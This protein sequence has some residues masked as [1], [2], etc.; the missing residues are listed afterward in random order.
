MLSN[1]IPILEQAVFTPRKL[2]V[3]C[4]GAGFSGLLLAYKWKHE[5][6]QDIMD[7]QIYEKNTDVGGTWLENTYP[8]VA[9]DVPAHIYTFPFEPNPDWSSFYANGSEIW[10]YIKRTA[11]KYALHEPIQFNSKVISAVWDEDSSQWKIRVDQQGKIFETTADILINGSGILNQWRWPDI[12]G[13]H[14]FR[15]QLVHSADWKDDLDCTKKRIAIIGNGSSAIQILPQLQPQAA[16]IVTYI[17]SPTWITTNFAADFTPEGKNFEYSDEQKARFRENPEELFQLRKKIEHGMN[18]FFHVLLADSPQQAGAR[19]LFQSEM[20]A[21]LKNNPTLCKLLIPKFE[22]G[23]RRLTPGEGYLEALQESNVKIRFDPIDKVEETGIIS[24]A[25]DLDLFD[26][27]ICATGFDVSFRP[28]WKM[29]G[30]DGVNL[31]EQWK[32]VPEA[33]FGI[34]APNMPNYFIFNGP[35]CPI[36]HGSLLSAMDAT[37]DYIM[38]WCRKISTEDI[39]SIAVDADATADYNVYSTEFHNAKTVWTGA[40]SSWFKHPTGKVTAMYAGNVLHYREILDRFRTEDFHVKY[41]SPN[42]F[43]FMGNGFTLRDEKGD[44]LAYY[45]TK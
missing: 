25:G 12:P 6:N 4:I 23:C 38:R 26:I 10:Q 20:E 19:E 42:R 43:K 30:R 40:C 21:K 2:R 15:G 11:E 24:H 13:L 35:N 29:I 17:R 22:V 33:Y 41:R 31:A 36:A 7:L 32:E 3:V 8:G 18:Q 16:Q 37:A 9:C 34:C 44:D 5:S 1:S 39:A 27:I 28:S 14:E 45:L